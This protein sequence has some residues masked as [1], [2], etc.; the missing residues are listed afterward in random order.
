MKE[1]NHYPFF[2]VRSNQVIVHPRSY[3]SPIGSQLLA[4]LCLFQLSLHQ[5]YRN[6]KVLSKGLPKKFSIDFHF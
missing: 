4:Q 6:N 1:E 3:G 2:C 5:L